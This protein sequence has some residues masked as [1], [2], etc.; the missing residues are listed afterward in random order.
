MSAHD[1]SVP[2]SVVAGGSAAAD[3]R[4]AGWVLVGLQA[5]LLGLLV[6]DPGRSA[7][8]VPVPLRVAGNVLRVSGAAAIVVAALRLGRS[9]SVHP[10][11]PAGAVLCTDGPYRFVRHPIYTGVLLLAAGIA[12]TAGSILAITT[13]GALVA[14]LAVKARLEEGLLRRRF[15]GYANYAASTPRFLPRPTRRA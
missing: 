15:P 5:G 8:T 13:F 9:A 14:V 2:V 10:A 7:W 12:A 4:A 3:P 1:G 11:P 6:L